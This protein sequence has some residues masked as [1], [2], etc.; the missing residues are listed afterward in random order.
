[1]RAKG[2]LPPT[3]TDIQH[4]HWSHGCQRKIHTSPT[5][6]EEIAVHIPAVYT[7]YKNKIDNHINTTIRLTFVVSFNKLE[8]MPEAHYAKKK[9]KGKKLD[10]QM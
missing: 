9:K 3:P 10:M 6:F 7:T 1:M 5:V 4:P 8:Y 2:E